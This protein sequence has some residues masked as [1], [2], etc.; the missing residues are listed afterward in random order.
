MDER[1]FEAEHPASRGLVDQLSAGA[2]EVDERGADVLHLVRDVMHPGAALSE[3]PPDGRVV[4]ERSEQLNAALADAER[5]GLDSLLVDTLPVLERRA[6]QP[7]IRVDRT[8][9]IVDGDADVVDR[10]RSSHPVDGM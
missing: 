9:E 3:E 7:R 1:N 8:V 5:G 6:E 10:E 2:G 4:A